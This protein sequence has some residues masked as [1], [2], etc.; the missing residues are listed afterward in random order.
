[1]NSRTNHFTL[2]ASLQV[3]IFLLP[4]KKGSEEMAADKVNKS[5]ESTDRGVTHRF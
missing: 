1:M 5:F 3:L 4:L 2:F